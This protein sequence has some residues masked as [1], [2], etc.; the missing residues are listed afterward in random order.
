MTANNTHHNTATYDRWVA[1]LLVGLALGAFVLSYAGMYALA[2]DSGFGWLSILWPLVTETA[3]VIFSL[4]YLVAK[5]KGYHNGYLMPLIVIC[6]GLSVTFNIAHA[7]V[8]NYL[9]RSAW[10]LPPLLLFCSFKVYIWLVENDTN[11]EG[12][13][14]TLTELHDQLRE[15][16]AKSDSLTNTIEHQEAK[17]NDILSQQ[18]EAKQVTNRAN[19]EEMNAAKDAKIEQRREQVLTLLSLEMSQ[20]DIAEQ[21]GVSSAT[22]R[23]DMKALNGRVS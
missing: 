12:A 6:T 13:I 8:A 11:R 23:R 16:T 7:P 3:V 5:L 22:V 21:L 20:K 10:A 19:V 17:L 15:M 9:S 2:I 4:V 14:T 1:R 18:T